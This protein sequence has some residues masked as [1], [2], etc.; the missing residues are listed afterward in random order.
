MTE[1][2]YLN[3]MLNLLH[4]HIFLYNLTEGIVFA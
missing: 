1:I 3:E 2:I 4:L